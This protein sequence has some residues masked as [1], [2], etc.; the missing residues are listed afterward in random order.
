[1]LPDSEPCWRFGAHPLVQQVMHLLIID[2]HI[3][4]AGMVRQ[5]YMYTYM[6]QYQA[7]WGKPL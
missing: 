4:A 1:M 6:Y 5:A 7:L 3:A 2:L